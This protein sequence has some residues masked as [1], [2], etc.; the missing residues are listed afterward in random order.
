LFFPTLVI[1]DVPVYNVPGT[2]K[3]LN[4]SPHTLAGIFLGQVIFWD[5]PLLV[6]D[7]PTTSLPHRKIVVVH[8]QDETGET[9][10]WTDY[11]CKVSDQWKQ[12][13]GNGSDISWPAGMTVAGDD[14]LVNAIKRNRFSIAYL[15]RWLAIKSGLRLGK[16]QNLAGNFVGPQVTSFQAAAAER[17]ASL[18]L[19]S[20]VSITNPSGPYSYPIAGFSGLLIPAQMPDPSK[21]KAMIDFIRWVIT[22]GQ[23]SAAKD[24]YIPLPKSVI[25]KELK[26]L[27]ALSQ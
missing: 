4:F 27:D 25:R 17:L 2:L 9:A 15:E 20:R 1:G 7:N 18:D 11:L 13:L 24:G 19:S 14:D 21:K 8:E 12:K 3:P 22:D 10:L 5:D 6:R 23:R 16:V 26:L